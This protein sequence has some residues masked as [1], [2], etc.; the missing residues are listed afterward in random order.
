MQLKS[1]YK[2][3]IKFKI[4]ANLNGSPPTEDFWRDALVRYFTPHR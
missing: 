3:K 4:T 1:N 2:N